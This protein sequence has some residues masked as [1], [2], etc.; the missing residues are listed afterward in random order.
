MIRSA[1]QKLSESGVPGASFSNVLELSGASRGA[2][3]HH[4][5]GGKEELIAEAIAYVGDGALAYL[6][7]AAGLPAVEV[8]DMYGR[9][10]R[11]VLV[12]G[13][14]KGGCA[15]A[16]VVTDSE[17]EPLVEA[18]AAIFRSWRTALEELLV[19]GGTPVAEAPAL[20]ATV[21]AT[22]EGAMLLSRAEGDIEIFDLIAGQLRS[23][24][25][26]S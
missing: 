19:D 4:F 12:S 10:W 9:M 3:Y 13:N 23:S 1:A 11:R 25:V 16:A 15:V 24:L 17:S 7:K 21:V 22:L 20:A 8:V 14:F 6:Q 2:I 5:P 18:A 26:H